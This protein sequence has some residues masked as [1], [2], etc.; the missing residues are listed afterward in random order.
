MIAL[1]EKYSWS[2]EKAASDD[3]IQML[4]LIQGFLSF[5]FHL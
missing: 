3:K 2:E 4:M 5:P 1:D